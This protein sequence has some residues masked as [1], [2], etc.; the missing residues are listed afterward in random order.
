MTSQLRLLLRNSIFSF[1]FSIFIILI[2]QQITTFQQ[3]VFQNINLFSCFR[4]CAL[5]QV[6]R[7]CFYRMSVGKEETW[8]SIS[9]ICRN[10]VSVCLLLLNCFRYLSRQHFQII[11]VCDFLNYLKYIQRGLVKS[12]GKHLNTSF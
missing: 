2:T 10:R 5:L 4:T 7:L 1:L 3:R 9:Q 8:Y 12:S 11:A 6:P